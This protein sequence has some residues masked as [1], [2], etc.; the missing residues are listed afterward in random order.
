MDTVTW[1][2]YPDD[3]H[4]RE[5]DTILTHLLEI[6]FPSGE[7]FLEYKG[8]FDRTTISRIPAYVRRHEGR[9]IQI[10]HI[11]DGSPSF[12]RCIK[13]NRVETIRSVQWWYHLTPI[14]IPSFILRT[15][16]RCRSETSGY[17]SRAIPLGSYNNIR[18]LSQWQRFR[19]GL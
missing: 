19:L 13:N 3:P 14:S 17:A 9:E 6:V 12:P 10:F 2:T 8:G 16:F 4:I 15:S 11:Q 5:Q 7:C 1:L 18:P